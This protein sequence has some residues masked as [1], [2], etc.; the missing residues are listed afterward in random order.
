MKSSISRRLRAALNALEHVYLK[1]QHQ[2]NTTGIFATITLLAMSSFSPVNN[3]LV[4]S[5]DIASRVVE[6][7]R[8]SSADQYM[9]LIPQLDGF[10]E[11][12]EENIS[13]YGPYL[14]EAKEEFTGTYV[15]ELLPSARESFQAVLREGQDKGIDWTKVVYEG[16]ETGKVSNASIAATWF[17]IRFSSEG[18]QYRLRVEKALV[19]HGNW[20]AGYDLSFI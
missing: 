11:V 19:I 12:M 18:N 14:S 2:M 20:S 17:T 8:R 3:T 7:L 5:Q 15:S 10:H 1:S 6:A 13:F 4:S 9:T 16:V